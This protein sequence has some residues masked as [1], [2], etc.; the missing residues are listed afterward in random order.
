MIIPKLPAAHYAA[1]ALPF[2]RTDDSERVGVKGW[3]AA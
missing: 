1:Q 2:A 3:E